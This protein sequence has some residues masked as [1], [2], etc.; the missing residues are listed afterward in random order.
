MSMQY[1]LMNPP[2]QNAMGAHLHTPPSVFQHMMGQ[3]N[4]PQ[5]AEQWMQMPQVP[6]LS[7]PW[8]VPSLQQPDVV[9]FT[10]EKV[11]PKGFPL[12]QKRKLE[13]PDLIET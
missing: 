5:E 11:S 13:M 7:M 2:V 12:H 8:S 4:A 6:Q 1:Q 10:G 3:Q 9:R